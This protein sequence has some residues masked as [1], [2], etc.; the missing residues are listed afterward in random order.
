MGEREQTAT[1]SLPLIS[2]NT[3]YVT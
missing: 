2:F 1:V 3:T